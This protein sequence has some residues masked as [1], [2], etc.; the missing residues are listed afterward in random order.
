MAEINKVSV[1]GE[2]YD[3]RDSGATRTTVIPN[4]SGEIKTKYRIAKK[5]YTGGATTY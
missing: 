3:I 1:K 5:D 2:T 4:D